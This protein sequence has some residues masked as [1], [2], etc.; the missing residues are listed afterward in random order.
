MENPRGNNNN[1]VES[2]KHI[3]IRLDVM[4]NKLSTII[5]QIQASSNN[6][7]IPVLYKF[8][9][10][11][12]KIQQHLEEVQSLL[13]R[14]ENIFNFNYL[15]LL[16]F[17]KAI[18]RFENLNINSLE[19]DYNS[20]E[21]LSHL[22]GINININ[23]PN[24]NNNIFLNRPRN[25]SNDDNNGNINLR[26][27]NIENNQENNL[28]SINSSN[29]NSENNLEN[30]SENYNADLPEDPINYNDQ[31]NI[32]NR[33]S[34]S[35][36]NRSILD[37]MK[38]QFNDY[39]RL[40]RKKKNNLSY[41]L[42]KNL[43]KKEQ[44]F[45]FIPGQIDSYLNNIKTNRK[46]VKIKIKFDNSET[47]LNNFSR[48]YNFINYIKVSFNNYYIRQNQ[49]VNSIIIFGDL[50]TIPQIR[51]ILKDLNTNLINIKIS[52]VEISLFY[53]YSDLIVD[54]FNNEQSKP[55]DYEELK[56]EFDYHNR[57]REFLANLLN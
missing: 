46:N 23:L 15:E 21:E 37:Q 57:M 52:K 50:K 5:D 13:N 1:N 34:V 33:R 2:I 51:N 28:E 40:F 48:Q 49:E 12:N 19:T 29:E 26:N 43:R 18:E 22:H 42:I 17:V 24:I 31:E 16:D 8:E 54:E 25:R 41:N 27:E 36:R 47:I 14:E 30:S 3:K 35:E 4:K 53:F 9:N 45:E 32:I 11:K 6:I 39:E 44:Y 10:F 20:L 55:I 38:E 7:L 56:K